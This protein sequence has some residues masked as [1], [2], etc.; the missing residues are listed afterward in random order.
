MILA[1]SSTT[2]LYFS[3]AC[4][5]SL[6]LPEPM[7][8]WA[9]VAGIRKSRAQR[10]HAGHRLAPCVGHARRSSQ[11][12]A[13]PGWHGG[14]RQSVEDGGGGSRAAATPAVWVCGVGHRALLRQIVALLQRDSLPCLTHWTH[15]LIKGSVGGAAWRV[16]CAVCGEQSD[17][18][19]FN[20]S[21]SITRS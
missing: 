17:F 14:R 9:R 11:I 6:D 15:A 3:A 20:G 2:P 16:R 18:L 1:A 19:A 7:A 13:T 4:M 10:S 12:P 8:P 21:E 5:P